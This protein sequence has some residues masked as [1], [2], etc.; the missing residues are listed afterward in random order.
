MARQSNFR[1]RFRLWGNN[2]N[3]RL[4]SARALLLKRSIPDCFGGVA[5]AVFDSDRFRRRGKSLWLQRETGNPAAADQRTTAE[6]QLRWTATPV[7]CSADELA[8]TRRPAIT[9]ALGYNE[10]TNSGAL[11]LNSSSPDG[12]TRPIA[13]LH[14]QMLLGS[15]SS[16]SVYM[17]LRMQKQTHSASTRGEI[18]KRVFDAIHKGNLTLHAVTEG[19]IGIE[20]SRSK[21]VQLVRVNGTRHFAQKVDKQLADLGIKISQA[22]ILAAVQSA[23]PKL[24]YAVNTPKNL[25]KN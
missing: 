8:P 24:I 25:F 9:E 12:A 1:R 22:R 10:S 17:W 2:F 16:S 7:E 15:F 13:L 5:K 6:S 14:I 19:L 11:A 23:T 20:E 3:S 18:A 4:Y 21:T